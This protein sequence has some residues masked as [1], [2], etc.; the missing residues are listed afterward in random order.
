MFGAI[1]SM[2]IVM[3]C[4]ISIIVDIKRLKAVKENTKVYKKLEKQTID[5]RTEVQIYV[6]E[7]NKNSI[8]FDELVEK[9]AEKLK[10]NV[11]KLR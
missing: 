9:V 1:I 4:V 5:F 10:E 7:Q 6:D 8:S 2:L 11:K 3:L